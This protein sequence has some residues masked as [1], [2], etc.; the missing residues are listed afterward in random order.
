MPKVI[1]FTFGS[2]P[3]LVTWRAPRIGAPKREEK[4]EDWWQSDNTE[5]FHVIGKDIVYFHA[6]FWPTMLKAAGFTLPTHVHVHG[7]LTVNGE[8]M[9][10]SRGTQI[11]AAT[12]AAHLDP[13]ALRYYYASKLGAGNDD[14]DLDFQDFT[15]KVNSDLVGK[16]VNLASRTAR[17]VADLGL[18]SAYPDD[19]GLFEAAASA[20]AEIAAAYDVFD[21]GKA[22]RLIMALADRANEY[23]DRMQPW[24]LKKQPGQERALQDV[25]T[26][27]LNLY[28]Q[29][30]VYL[31]PILPKLANE[32]SA[33]L[34]ASVSHWS[35]AST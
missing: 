11:Q 5:I 19:G 2:M 31:S 13:E 12:Y 18:S 9:S 35:D 16:V 28:R 21:T 30:I 6:L 8:K 23:V 17:F 1:T 10:K 7:M 32:S 24:A 14:I 22:T 33:L 27:S 34:A 15:Q 3:P 4:F 29:L 26:V 25:C 20:G